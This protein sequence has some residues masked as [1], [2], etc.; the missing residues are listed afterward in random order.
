LAGILVREI[1]EAYKRVITEDHSNLFS[2]T[3]IPYTL[4]LPPFHCCRCWCCA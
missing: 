1:A 4:H 2:V 3:P